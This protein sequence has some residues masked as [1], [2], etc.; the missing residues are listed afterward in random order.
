MTRIAA[1]KQT[2]PEHVTVCLEDGEEIRSTL[3]TVTELRLYNGRELDE[4]RLC[5]LR[6]VSGRALAREKALQLVS[7]RQMSARE[8]SRKLREKGFD[9]QAADYCVS[10]VTEHGLLDEERYAA[11]I[12]RHYSAKGYGEGRLR[13][14]LQKRGIPRE[15]SDEALEE[16]PRDTGKL[17]SFVAAR[18][19]DPEDR[20]AVRKLSAA[21]YRRG[22]SAV[23]IRGAL[24]RARAAYDFED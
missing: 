20:D 23:E 21:L 11:A 14:E 2:T 12:V 19:K 8:L 13:Q 9:E 1:L 16:R 3:G 4:E 22:Y 24:D 7:Q 17:D 6:L 18:L 15:L 5:E 10:W